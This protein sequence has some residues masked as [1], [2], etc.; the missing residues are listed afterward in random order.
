MLL[1]RCEVRVNPAILSSVARAFEA[2]IVPLLRPSHAHP[3]ILVFDGKEAIDKLQE[4]CR[5]DDR[6]LAL[7][8]GRALEAQ[9]F[10]HGASS[11]SRLRDSEQEMYLSLIHI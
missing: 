2:L 6:N 9:D 11:S 4:I 8:L 5:I 7:L 1:G 3:H 10:L